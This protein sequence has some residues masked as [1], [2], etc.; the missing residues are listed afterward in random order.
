MAKEKRINRQI[1]TKWIK[2]LK[3][4]SW[5]LMAAVLFCLWIWKL[6]I[7]D[8]LP[9]IFGSQNVIIVYKIIGASFLF[10]VV[11]IIVLE[12]WEQNNNFKITK[13]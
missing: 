13:D 5:L 3:S 11:F 10:L 4:V 8:L 1:F 9:W 6:F 7:W 2:S 12:P